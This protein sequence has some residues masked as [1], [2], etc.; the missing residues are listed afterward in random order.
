MEIVLQDTVVLLLSLGQYI[1]VLKL[2][3]IFLNAC[4]C[5]MINAVHTV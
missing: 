3:K 2:L 4:Q 1:F 5:E